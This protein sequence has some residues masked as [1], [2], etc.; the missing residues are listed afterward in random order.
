MTEKVQ[1]SYGSF[2]EQELLEEIVENGIYK[3]IPAGT[4]ILKIDDYIKSIPL[5]LS[6]AIKIMREDSDGNEL[7]LYYLEQGESC[8]MTMTC[9]IA[10]KKSEIKAVT[11]VDTEL[12]FIPISKMEEW[13]GKYKSWRNFVFNSYNNRL[14]ELFETIDN[15]AF[16]KMDERLLNYLLEK[17]NVLNSNIISTTHQEIAYEMNTSRVV[18]SRLLKKLEQLKKVK[19]YRNYIEILDV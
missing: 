16:N 18:I 17:K 4:T 19:L 5:L 1:E 6:G 10:H 12:L 3:A 9:C 7:L 11:E 14:N 13:S 15:I 8:S 2:F